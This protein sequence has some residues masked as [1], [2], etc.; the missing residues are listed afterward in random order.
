VDIQVWEWFVL[1]GSE[2]DEEREELLNTIEL[3]WR[4]ENGPDM[5]SVFMEKR[6]K[7][8]GILERL[9]AEP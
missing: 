7:L 8:D 2:T 9:P 1:E 6:E 5:H 4:D 3:S